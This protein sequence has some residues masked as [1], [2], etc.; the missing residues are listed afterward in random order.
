MKGQERAQRLPLPS[1]SYKMVLFE[2]EP[3]RACKSQLPISAPQVKMHFCIKGYCEFAENHRV[4]SL[5]FTYYI[6]E[7]AAFSCGGKKKS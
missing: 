6:C 3:R 4:F 1:E 2:D 7:L 5:A